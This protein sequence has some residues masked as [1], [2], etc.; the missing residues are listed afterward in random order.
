MLEFN[1]DI[2]QYTYDGNVVPS[3]TQVIKGTGFVDDRWFTDEARERGTIVH[4]AVELFNHGTLDMETVDE[5]T[6]GYLRGWEN[7]IFAFGM[8]MEVAEQRVYNETYRYA[9]TLDYIGVS[10]K[11]KRYL[12]DVK[13]GT[14]CRS[15][16]LQLAAYLA[17]VDKIDFVRT[18]YL[19]AD[20]K[21]NAPN[22]TLTDEWQVFTCALVCHNWN[23]RR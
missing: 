9:G 5:E 17:C 11:G 2:H 21:Y 1:E 7:F 12:I 20:G 4:K 16:H 23:Q 3:V 14:P 13:T 15:H 22:V 6:A 10:A 8:E 18:V 19:S